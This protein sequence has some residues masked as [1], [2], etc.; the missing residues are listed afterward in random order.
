M[1]NLEGY[2]RVE[3]F[4]SLLYPAFVKV[5]VTN[6][7]TN[8]VF[9]ST[10]SMFSSAREL[11]SNVT[12]TKSYLRTKMTPKERNEDMYLVACWVRKIQ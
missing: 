11:K 2:E 8:D 9:V 1:I 3:S 10:A 12:R 5:V 4:E 6:I 7:V